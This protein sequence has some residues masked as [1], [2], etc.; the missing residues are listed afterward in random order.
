M[1]TDTMLSENVYLADSDTEF[2]LK[3]YHYNNT[4]VDFEKPLSTLNET[5]LRNTR[6][7]I[8]SNDDATKSKVICKTFGYIDEY[9]ENQIDDLNSI[10]PNI[11]TIKIYEANEGFYIR[12]YNYKN[13]WFVSTHKRINAFKS[14]WIV[15]SPITHGDLFIDCIRTKHKLSP[16]LSQN[17]VLQKLT[18]TLDINTI[19][20][21]IVLNDR[22]NRIVCAA[23]KTPTMF[24]F[25]TFDAHTMEFKGIDAS[26]WDPIK[27]HEGVIGSVSENWYSS[28][29]AINDVIKVA[30]D[31]D[32]SKTQGVLI[33]IPETSKLIKIYNDKYYDYMMIRGNIP[34]VPFR[35]LQLRNNKE[36]VSKLV[37]LYPEWTHRFHAYETIMRE[38]INDIFKIYIRRH[39]YKQYCFAQK[40]YHEFL[41]SAVQKINANHSDNDVFMILYNEFS[42]QSAVTLN[43]MIK[44][45]IS[46][47]TMK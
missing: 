47:S 11:E 21:F 24:Q 27:Q 5:V 14:K 36:Q 41:K 17:Q 1:T 3:L 25:A 22:Y 13:K 45:Y 37:E 9:K 33:Y 28:M 42:N 23:P 30:H 32:I 10:I 2:N 40:P 19:Y 8:M 4:H 6:G 15:N 35:Y 44:L 18:D 16:V 38:I 20:M 46:N 29:D 7:V 34:S 26:V 39:V 12:V 31:V 43:K